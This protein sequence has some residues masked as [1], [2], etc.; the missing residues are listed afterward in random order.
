MKCIIIIS[1]ILLSLTY[2]SCDNR[3]QLNTKEP[4][5][6]NE[7]FKEAKNE[8]ELKYRSR[9]LNRKIVCIDTVSN[10]K[11]LNGKKK[12]VL[13]YT[14]LDC[15]SCIDKGFSLIKQIS[16]ISKN[17]N[18]FVIASNSNIGFD[19]ER[20]HYFDYIYNDNEEKIR[21]NLNY[22][23]TPILLILDKDNTIIEI[24]FPETNMIVSG[25][26]YKL[27]DILN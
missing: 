14:G 23:H 1:V 3:K 25:N 20:N 9:F 27:L 26:A 5:V 12:A 16:K 22:L 13:I 15:Q 18:A 17:N 8:R 6:Y 24:C 2:Y 11:Y 21:K 7:N 10:F 4:A 19:Q